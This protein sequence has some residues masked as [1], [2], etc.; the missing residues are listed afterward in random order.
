M[1]VEAL[2]FEHRVRTACT[3]LVGFP[4]RVRVGCSG[5]ADEGSLDPERFPTY[6]PVCFKK[7]KVLLSQKIQVSEGCSSLRLFFHEVRTFRIA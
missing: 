7:P 1:L 5:L 6:H 2:P 4:S 3:A